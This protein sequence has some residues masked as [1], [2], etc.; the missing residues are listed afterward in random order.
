[1]NLLQKIVTSKRDK[2][3]VLTNKEELE[4]SLSENNGKNSAET[5]RA[6]KKI[7]EQNTEERRSKWCRSLR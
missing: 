4:K 3:T 5:M 1:M 7:T 2:A 6:T